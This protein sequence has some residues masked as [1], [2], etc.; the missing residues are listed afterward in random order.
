MKQEEDKFEDFI[1]N[2]LSEVDP[3]ASWNMPDDSNWDMI[4]AHL[5]EE[6]ER[7]R[8]AIWWIPTSLLLIIGL[9]LGIYFNGKTSET[10]KKAT[11]INT[12][13]ALQQEVSKIEITDKAKSS[14]INN[15]VKESPSSASVISTST[16]NSIAS[17]NKQDK[18][19]YDAVS[20]Q[21]L[22]AGTSKE[23][24][25]SEGAVIAPI[26]S[27]LP[28]VEKAKEPISDPDI[29]FEE[30]I[31]PSTIASIA[32]PF[33]FVDERSLDLPIIKQDI[34]PQLPNKSFLYAQT[35]NHFAPN[36]DLVENSLTELVENEVISND[37]N[38]ELGIQVPLS[39]DIFIS[40]GFSY[41]QFDLNTAYD[42][43]LVY[44]KATE[45][46]NG[47]DRF[48]VYNHSLPTS[49]G[50]IGTQ[51]VMA[52][53]ASNMIHD[54]ETL[55]YTLSHQQSVAYLGIPVGLGIRKYGFTLHSQILNNWRFEHKVE[56]PMVISK[57]DIIDHH[58][59]MATLSDSPS[60]SYYMGLRSSIS[61]DISLTRG[62]SM[63][64]Q[65]GIQSDL[66]GA[67]YLGN[68][69]AVANYHVGLHLLYTL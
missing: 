38:V 33:L 49:A 37:L 26:S 60:N 48:N 6:D 41:S 23:H 54:Q 62:F 24:V 51:V 61:Y 44:E 66:L 34:T 9:G 52:R 5:D 10:I 40:S 15:T 31:S 56:N 45:Q 20:A 55:A 43:A 63:G 7:K 69:R 30:I 22:G 17:D 58:S 13:L 14:A 65:S 16:T 18:R 50:N 29:L 67:Y 32:P 47:L 1:K 57:H 35:L 4:E 46:S 25:S 64:V 19:S 12:S 42:V 28:L 27:D 8:F 11:P 68:K 2:Q 36:T 39:K 21:S 3:N 53:S 59:S